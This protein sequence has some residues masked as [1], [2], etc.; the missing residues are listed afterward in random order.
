MSRKDSVP[1]IK[2]YRISHIFNCLKCIYEYPFNRVKQK[3]CIMKL[4]PGKSEQS[5][6]RGMVIPSLRALGFILGFNDFIK[7]SANGK[8]ILES[9]KKSNTLFYKTLRVIFYEIDQEYFKVLDIF[10]RISDI[11]KEELF[12]NFENNIESG[13]LKQKKERFNHWLSILIEIKL[14]NNNNNNIIYLLKENFSQSLYDSD[15]RNKELIKFK[16]TLLK[17]YL[18]LSPKSAG[19]VDIVNLREDVS[20]Y[21]LKEQII[22]SEKQFDELLSRLP[23][24][25]SNEYII[26]LGSPI[27]S[28]KLFEYENKKYRTLTIRILGKKHGKSYS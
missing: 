9:K 12:N 22:L 25:S 10:H 4:Y 14:L 7:I 8:L 19:I 16:N 28:G 23:F 11:S 6:F 17:S 2:E 15:S 24:I 27:G 20:T 3:E 21:Y 1:L 26:S 13:S 18:E 5:V